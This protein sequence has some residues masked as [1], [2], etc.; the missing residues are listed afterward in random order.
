MIIEDAPVIPLFY[1][2]VIRLVNK[3]ISG[4]P[5]NSINMLDLRRVKKSVKNI[6]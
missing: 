1:D 3:R 4:L 2:E 5:V 6:E